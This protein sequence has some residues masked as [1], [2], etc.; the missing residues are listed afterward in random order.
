MKVETIWILLLSC[1]VLE[2][3]VGTAHSLKR[4]NRNSRKGGGTGKGG[5]GKGGTRNRENVERNQRIGARTNQNM[6]R[7]NNNPRSTSRT[8]IQSVQGGDSN[9]S[10]NDADDGTFVAK[11]VIAYKGPKTLFDE[12][13]LAAM[14]F[15]QN[16]IREIYNEEIGSQRDMELDQVTFK[17][18]RFVED[19]ASDNSNSDTSRFGSQGNENGKIPRRPQN[20]KREC[21]K[22][23][24]KQ[25]SKA[26]KNRCNR[27]TSSPRKRQRNHSK[28]RN[29]KNDSNRRRF[30][31][32]DDDDDDDD[33]SKKKGK[34]RQLR[35]PQIS[36]RS[37]SKI[38]RSLKVLNF[39]TTTGKCRSCSDSKKKELLK[40]DAVRF[41]SL[42][43]DNGSPPLSLKDFQR[44][45]QQ[46]YRESL[47]RFNQRLV[48]VLTQ[49]NFRMFQDIEE[50]SIANDKFGDGAVSKSLFM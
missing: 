36:S 11:F 33:S 47:V 10:N 40:N 7:T 24:K 16:S 39:Y 31:N 25:S 28:P 4:R 45:T 14:T 26:Y 1:L 2:T 44:R 27:K 32:G 12:S 18:Q 48:R 3:A 38:G 5:T 13:N 49:S 35:T 43:K 29:T 34:R 46:T 19:N 20:E 50:A 6:N 23:G 17:R 42:Q 21:I 37:L 22:N 9:N 8:G 41:L 30:K 15:L